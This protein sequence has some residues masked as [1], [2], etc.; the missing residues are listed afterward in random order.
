[1]T[2]HRVKEDVLLKVA[3]V[4]A[5]KGAEMAFPTRTLYMEDTIQ[6]AQNQ[7]VGS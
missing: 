3:E 4:V 6:I 7:Q 5:E 2:Y 1:V